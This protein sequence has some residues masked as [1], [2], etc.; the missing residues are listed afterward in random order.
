MSDDK[1]HV[2]R[3][4]TSLQK[5]RDLM[6]TR[7]A[8]D[9]E[10]EVELAKETNA[11]EYTSLIYLRYLPD[12]ENQEV[13]QEAFNPPYSVRQVADVL[14]AEIQ[15]AHKKGK[16]LPKSYINNSQRLAA[17]CY[18]ALTERVHFETQPWYKFFRKVLIPDNP[19]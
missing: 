15:Q 3:I 5:T 7:S 8:S 11:V 1:K 19:L 14:L 9:T 16:P 4:R 18:L 6:R 2:S 10:V 17:Q 12:R 13:R